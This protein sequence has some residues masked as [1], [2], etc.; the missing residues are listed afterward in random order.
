MQT[1]RVEE[2]VMSNGSGRSPPREPDY[3]DL[4]R[5]RRIQ[6][7]AALRAAR[8]HDEQHRGELRSLIVEC[9]AMLDGDCST[10]T[11]EEVQKLERKIAGPLRRRR[12]R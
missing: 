6:L 2:I 11:E 7:E 8:K 9:D 12:R 4:L 3:M 1:S 5:H 10:I